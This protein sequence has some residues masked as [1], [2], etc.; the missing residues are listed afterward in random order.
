MLLK[1]ITEVAGVA[2]DEYEVRDVIREELKG[3]D[4]NIETDVLGNLIVSQ[5]GEFKGPRVMIAA[6]MDEIGLMIIAVESNGL[7]K[8]TA[9]GGID[10]KVLVAKTV[11]VGKNKIPGVIGSKAIHLQKPEE[12]QVPLPMDGLYIDIGA[13]SKEDAEKFVQIGDYAVFDTKYREFG[14]GFAKAKAFDDRIGCAVLLEVLKEKYDLPLY[15]VFTVSEEIGLRGAGIAAY[16]IE[17]DIGIALEGT[18]AHDVS[19]MDDHLVSSVLRKGPVLT[20]LDLSVIS[21]KKLVALAAQS[22]EANNIPYQYRNVMAGGNDSGKINQ[23]KAGVPTIEIA[24]PTRY[25]HSPVSVIHLEDFENTVK[26]V[27]AFIHSIESGG[28]EIK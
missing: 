9:V 25:V 27:K 24:V 28:F 14:D 26:L 16:K 12:R 4:L 1:R 7:L 18:L 10:P 8:F 2:G 23:T 13:K 11:V 5:K 21:D 17:P 6:H 3:Y 19:D 22:A 20:Y 15:G